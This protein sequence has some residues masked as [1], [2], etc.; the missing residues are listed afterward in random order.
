MLRAAATD[1]GRLYKRQLVD[2]LDVREGTPSWMR[3]RPWHRSAH[4]GRARR[5]HRHGGRCRP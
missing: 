5:G 3:V 1:V 2:L 4:A